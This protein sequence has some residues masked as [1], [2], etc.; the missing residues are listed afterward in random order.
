MSERTR[1]CP[2]CEAGCSLKVQLKGDTIVSCRGNEDDRFSRG[3]I[4]PKGVA[5]KELHEDPDRLRAPLVRGAS[6]ELQPASWD[7]A[8]ERV[9]KGLWEV[10]RAHGRDAVATYIGNPTAHNIS[11]GMGLGV[12]SQALASRSVFS[13]GSVDQLPKQLAMELMFGDGMAIPVPDIERTEHLMILGANPIVSNGSL[14]VV[15]GIRGKLRSLRDRGGKLVVIDPRRSETAALA[16]EHH[17]I[18]PGTDAWLLSAIVKELLFAG[19][20]PELPVAGLDRLRSSISKVSLDEAASRTGVPTAVIR[21]LAE[22]L[23]DARS[24]AVYGRVGTTLQRFGTLTSFL[25][26]VV[27]LLTGNLDRPGGAMFPQQPF[28]APPKQARSNSDALSYARYHSRVSGYPEVLGQLPVACLAEEIETP[29]EGQ[30]RAMLLVAGNP[31]VSNPES[32][33][34]AEAFAG[35]D[36]MLSI[37][38]YLNESNRHADVIL[39]G[40][41]PFEEPHYASFLG[42]MTYRN[43]ARYSEPLLD[44]SGQPSEWQL[45]LELAYLVSAGKRATPEELIAF[46]DTVLRAAVESYLGDTELKTDQVLAE[47]SQHHG[48]ARMLDLGIRMGPW[49]DG[50]GAREGLTLARMADEENSIDMGPLTSRVDDVVRHAD[51]RIHLGPDV[52]MADLDRLLSEPGRRRSAARRAP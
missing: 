40:T 33:R 4:C 44:R 43:T 5:L 37:D 8:F 17:F 49:G 22:D 31:V 46:E 7:E 26:D 19:C 20:A 9:L 39:P 21:H 25:V 30:I 6:G 42:A 51:A 35:L 14:W 15:P 3:H 52:L 38:L 12:L 29:G 50:F 41:S 10:R 32:A 18:R 24:A 11:L 23:R 1:I 47:L 45:M 16:D 27:N 28:A 34:L 48:V 2:I 36:F 13:A